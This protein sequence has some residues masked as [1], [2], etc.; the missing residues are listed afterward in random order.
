[1]NSQASNKLVNPLPSGR[2]A[3]AGR[4][5]MRIRSCALAGAS[6]AR[7]RASGSPACSSLCDGTHSEVPLPSTDEGAATRACACLRPPAP[8]IGPRTAARRPVTF[9][10]SSMPR[11]SS[12]VPNLPPSKALSAPSVAFGG[13]LQAHSPALPCTSGAAPGT[14]SARASRGPC[15][16]RAARGT[17]GARASMWTTSTCAA[18]VTARGTNSGAAGPSAEEGAVPPC[19]TPWSLKPRSRLLPSRASR[20]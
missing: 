20:T 1:M 7:A 12:T 3:H 15:T 14:A 16:S 18:K 5:L 2:W 10:L 9:C 6:C 11:M 4:I 19:S 8:S 17:A 13:V